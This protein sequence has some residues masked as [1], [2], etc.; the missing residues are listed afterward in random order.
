MDLSSRCLSVVVTGAAGF[1]GSRITRELL[2][3]GCSVTTFVRPGSSLWRLTDVAS[4]VLSLE[5]DFHDR[6][7]TQRALDRAQAKLLIHSAWHATP[8]VYLTDPG[9]VQDLQ[10]SLGLFEEARA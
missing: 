6:A 1:I 4:S 3:R 10:A 7:A 5:V 2:K 9:N 8:G